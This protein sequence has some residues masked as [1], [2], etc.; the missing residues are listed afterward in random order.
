MEAEVAEVVVTNFEE[1]V[2]LLTTVIE[3]VLFTG[4]MIVGALAGVTLLKGWS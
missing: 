1:I 3:I 4:S 2:L